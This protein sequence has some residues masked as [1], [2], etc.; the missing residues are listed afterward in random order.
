MITTFNNA[1]SAFSFFKSHENIGTEIDFNDEVYF[2]VGTGSYCWAEFVDGIIP[3]RGNN[4]LFTHLTD[5]ELMM[6]LSM[7]QDKDGVIWSDD[8]SELDEVA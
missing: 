7:I 4:K 8:C 2:G 3:Q 1:E 5:D 6:V